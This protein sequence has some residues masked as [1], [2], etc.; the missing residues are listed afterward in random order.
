[1]ETFTLSC[2]CTIR[3]MNDLFPE[4]LIQNQIYIVTSCNKPM[5]FRQKEH[6]VSEATGM[7]A[8]YLSGIVFQL[9]D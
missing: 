3:S 4:T 7:K 5:S 2:G 1:M 8:K 6:F 9:S